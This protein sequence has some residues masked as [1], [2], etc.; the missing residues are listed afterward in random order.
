MK[1]YEQYKYSGIEWLGQVPEHWEVKKFRFLFSFRKGL[2]ITKENLQ[3]TGIPC[4]NY[5]EIHSKYGFSV[6]PKIDE[7]KCVS[8]D[9]LK[10]NPKS[11]LNYGDFVFADT[12]ED[13]EGSGNFT[14]LNSDELTFA[15]YHTI[16][17]SLKEQHYP[18]FLAYIFDSLSFRNQIRQR[19]KGVKVFSITQNILKDNLV[20]LPP[21][22]E[23]TA[24]AEFLDEKTTQIQTA[25]GIKNE[26]IAELKEYRQALINQTVTK[27]LNT[28]TPMKNSGVQWLGDVPGHWECYPLWTQ[29]KPKSIINKI[30][31]PLLSVYLDKGVIP[32][33]EV[34]EKRTNVTSLDLSKYQF[35]EVGD[36]VLNNQQ[37]W[38]GSVGVS[39]Y[40]GIVSPAYLVL[41]LSDKFDRNFA[42]YLFRNGAMVAHYL[43]SSKGVGTIQRNLYWGQL[44]NI[45]IFLPPLPEQLAIANFLDAKTAQIDT[46][47][48]QYQ[49]Q[50]E[51]LKEYRQSLVNEVVTGKMRV[52]NLENNIGVN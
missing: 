4:V 9:Y 50:I 18:R 45:P 42:N 12:S 51:R 46:A 2:A 7:L 11:L 25:I 8:E 35:V 16:I 32:F 48:N 33:D 34:Q 52:S 24:I 41:S 5:G 19:V 15:G 44:K 30:D 14:Y 3:E 1:P 38:R 6:N 13:I 22:P 17:C 43:I 31:E 21:L 47:I 26:Q 20:W 36:F 37:A 27:G 23:Q 10:N 28:N 40:Q 39:K 49:A 29:A